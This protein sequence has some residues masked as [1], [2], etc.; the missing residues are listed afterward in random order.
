MHA[1]NNFGTLFLKQLDHPQH[2]VVA[3]TARTHEYLLSNNEMTKMFSLLPH[4]RFFLFCALDLTSLVTSS[5]RLKCI[6]SL[7]KNRN[8]QHV[9][10]NTCALFYSICLKNLTDHNSEIDID[11][12]FFFIFEFLQDR[13]HLLASFSNLYRVRT[14]NQE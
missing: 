8:V 12:S 7:P 10:K 3:K 2:Q 1:Q 14:I 5:R 4:Q 11:S 9:Y 6:L 13:I